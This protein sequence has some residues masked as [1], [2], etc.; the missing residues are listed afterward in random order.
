[1]EIA[2]PISNYYGLVIA[3]PRRKNIMSEAGIDME[4]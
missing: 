4:E 2:F 3:M 1:M